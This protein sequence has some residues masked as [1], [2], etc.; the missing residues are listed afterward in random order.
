MTGF[1]VIFKITLNFQLILFNKGI[2]FNSSLQT[3]FSIQYNIQYSIFYSNGIFKYID[4]H[5]KKG[6]FSLRK[7][8][9]I[10]IISFNTFP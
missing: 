4:Y 7:S 6:I 2:K 1:Q 9:N 5:L 3:V 10:L 8:E